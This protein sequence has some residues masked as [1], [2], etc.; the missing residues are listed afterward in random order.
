MSQIAIKRKKKFGRGLYAN[1]NIKPDSII[2]IS[3]I[4]I[5]PPSQT[6]IAESTILGAY[7]YDYKKGSALALGLGSLFNHKDD[8]NVDYFFFN[9]KLYFRTNRLIK[10]GEQLFIDYGYDPTAKK[11]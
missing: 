4:I 9:D 7:V 11:K 6:K 3:E 5:F 10:K 1:Q 2:E 8:P